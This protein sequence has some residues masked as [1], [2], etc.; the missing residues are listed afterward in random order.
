[1]IARHPDDLR[2]P[3]LERAQRP[4]NV[5]GLLRYV[6]DDKQ[7]VVGRRPEVLDELPVGGEGYMQVADRQQ[8]RQLSSP[9]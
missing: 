6:A 2:E 3:L 4:F 7:P 5:R 9:S 1:M 8:S